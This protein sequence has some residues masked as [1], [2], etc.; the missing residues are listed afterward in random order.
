ME[1]KNLTKGMQK[2]LLQIGYGVTARLGGYFDE[3]NNRVDLRSAEA[4]FVR[5][6]V[7][8]YTIGVSPLRGKI[9]LTLA[10]WEMFEGLTK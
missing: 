4:L 5:K 10:G 9:D 6:L 7:A 1:A 2:A 8:Y 3:D